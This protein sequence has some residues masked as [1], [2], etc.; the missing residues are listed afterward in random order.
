[1]FSKMRDIHFSFIGESIIVKFANIYREVENLKFK[2]A[3]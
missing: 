3:L 2:Y 1:M